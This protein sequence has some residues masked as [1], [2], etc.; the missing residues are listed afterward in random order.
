MNFG[1]ILVETHKKVVVKMT[2]DS[3]M[4]LVYEWSFLEDSIV[5]KEGEV[6]IN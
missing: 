4:S 1:A 6:A 2:N 5:S 3:L